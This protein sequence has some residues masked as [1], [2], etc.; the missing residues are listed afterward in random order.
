MAFEYS[1]MLALGFEPEI[2]DKKAKLPHGFENH[3]LKFGRLIAKGNTGYSV[4]VFKT[5]DVRIIKDLLSYEVPAQELAT[6]KSI[7]NALEDNTEY[8]VKMSRVGIYESLLT[9]YKEAVMT[10]KI[11]N[12]TRNGVK[13]SDLVC[14]PFLCVPMYK[15]GWQLVFVSSVAKG[16]TVSK[17]MGF[18]ARNFLWS[19]N[20]KMYQ[21][22]A[23]ACDRLWSLGFAHNDL[24]PGNIMYDEKSGKVTFIDLESTVEVPMEASTAYVERRRSSE[25]N[26]DCDKTFKQTMAYDAEILLEKS[27]KWINKFFTDGDNELPNPDGDFLSTLSEIIRM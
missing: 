8:I 24:H 20:L 12:T 27:S 21:T 10:N 17:K 5:N 11:Y 7:F 23:K 16:K 6:Y 25:S 18:F 4:K 13:G 2:S 15:H 1:N 26:E 3:K 19:R 9:C 22:L 14:K